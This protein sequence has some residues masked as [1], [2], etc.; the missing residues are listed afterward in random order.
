MA[1]IEITT[2]NLS[3]ELNSSKTS[4]D[5]WVYVPGT[6]ITGDYT[7]PLLFTTIEEFKNACGSRGPE[8]SGTFEYVTGL[9]SAGMPVMF[10]RIACENQDSGNDNPLVQKA[11]ATFQHKDGETDEDVIDFVVEEKYG[12]TFGNDLTVKYNPSASAIWLDVYVGGKSLIERRRLAIRKGDT[13]TVA[14]EVIKSLKSIEFDRISIDPDF[15]NEDYTTFDVNTPQE[16]V[17]TGGMDFPEDNVPLEIPQ[18]YKFIYDK[19]LFKPK[20]ITS[21]GYTD[22]LEEGN[23]L[24]I[25]NAMLDITRARQDCAAIID[26]P[27]G[28]DQSDYE[29]VAG[30]LKYNQYTDNS[31]IPSGRIFGP[32]VYMRIGADSYW[33]PPSYAYLT[34]M[35]N[36]LSEGKKPYN[37][38]AGLSTGVVKNVIRTEFEIGTSIAESWQSDTRVNINPIM[39]INGSTYAIGGNSTLLEPEEEIGE[40]NLFTESSA[41]LAVI[42]IRRFVYNLATEL[43]FQYNSTEVFETFGLRTSDYL[44]RMI[45]EGAVTNYAIYNESTDLEPRKLK[46]R[47]DVYLSPTVKKIEILL[48]VG[49]GSV[50]LE[51]EGGN[52]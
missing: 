51:T 5:N 49:Y 9:L 3:R 13:E 17:L 22:S 27:I 26:L 30:S 36:R 47:L 10:R 34:T 46:I 35:G 31:A 14:K 38:V 19:M 32:W 11:K 25:A 8:D 33:M 7:K 1:F 28:A 40:N 44:D 41:D 2:N 39:K 43:Q 24:E 12:G 29:S 4:I 48:N 20:F 21:G 50:E 45:S 6:A 42:D 37:P 18:S 52:Y 23:G 15:L 16:L